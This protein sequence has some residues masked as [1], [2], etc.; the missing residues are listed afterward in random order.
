MES[1]HLLPDGS[2]YPAT[3]SVATRGQGEGDREIDLEA[4]INRTE[5]ILETSSIGTATTSLGFV[6]GVITRNGITWRLHVSPPPPLL[7]WSIIIIQ[8]VR[9]NYGGTIHNNKALNGEEKFN[10]IAIITSWN[11]TPYTATS[12]EFKQRVA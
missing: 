4:P 9:I 8:Q 10:S 12:F 2:I 11:P 7:L 5:G 1:Q 6:S 3:A